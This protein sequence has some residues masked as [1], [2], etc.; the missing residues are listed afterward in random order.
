MTEKLYPALYTGIGKREPDAAD[1]LPSRAKAKKLKPEDYI[2]GKE[3]RD[4]VNVALL[5]RKPLLLT[6]EPG[7]GKTQL[8]ASI[9]WELGLD[10]PL[11]FETKSTSQARDLFYV[12]DA[13]SR[14]HARETQADKILFLTYGALGEALVRTHDEEA[15]RSHLPPE[16]EHGGRRQSVVLIDEVD[17]A[18]RDFPND[19]LNELELGYFRIPELGKVT[20]RA[21]PELMPILVIT[22][23]SEKDLPNA[24][25]R[26]CV[27]HHITFPDRETLLKIVSRRLGMTAGGSSD[28]LDDALDLFFLLRNGGLLKRPATAELLDWVLLLRQLRPEAENPVTDRDLL[29]STLSTLVKTAE[30]QP[31]AGEL[32]DRWA[33][34][35][36]TKTG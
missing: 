6:G 3:L 2:S 36:S 14:F 23:N 28:F 22:S 26:R 15:V 9:A 4:A 12:Y 35:S 31:K 33:P 34:P 17:K 11:K 19:L 18:P 16:F 10:E 5:L 25:L 13:L 8:A 7:T 29:S 20:V 24:F 32:V 1:R 27:F 21:D 30:D